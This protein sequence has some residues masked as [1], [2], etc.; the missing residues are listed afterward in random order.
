MAKYEGSARLA[1]VHAIARI[2]ARCTI[3]HAISQRLTPEYDTLYLAASRLHEAAVQIIYQTAKWSLL[4]T[5]LAAIWRS[6]PPTVSVLARQLVYSELVCTGQ[7][8][9]ET[10]PESVHVTRS[11][12]VLLMHAFTRCCSAS[13]E[14]RGPFTHRFGEP[15]R[16]LATD[17][18]CAAFANLPVPSERSNVPANPFLALC[19]H[20]T[21]G[22]MLVALEPRHVAADTAII[23]RS[24]Q[25]TAERSPNCVSFGV[26]FGC[27]DPD[28]V[29]ELQPDL[30][31][32]CD[33]CKST[34]VARFS[35][36]RYRLT[37][38]TCTNKKDAHCAID[39]RAIRTTKS[40]VELDDGLVICSSH[41]ESHPWLLQSM[42]PRNDIEFI[43]M[44]HK[45]AHK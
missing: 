36:S 7:C 18:V 12:P 27:F 31:V 33:T 1:C 37:R 3:M 28:P 14:L 8:P 35:G 30:G 9:P 42:T 45:R 34:H 19:Q 15:D 13:P 17:R 10:L 44:I 21:G 29:L 38:R 25:I 40:I 43:R 6:Q 4:A 26:C 16:L 23:A 32:R 2:D 11:F 22:G 41:A 20:A 5:E 39:D 24:W